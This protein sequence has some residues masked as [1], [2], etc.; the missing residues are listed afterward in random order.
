MTSRTMLLPQNA[1]PRRS[2][3]PAALV[4]TVLLFVLVAAACTS[5]SGGERSAD[6]LDLPLT[7]PAGEPTTLAAFTGK[8][9]VVNFFASWCGPCKAEL[10]DIEAVSKEYA[11]D[12]TIVGV[13][14]DATESS[15]LSLVDEIGVTFPTVFE[16]QTGAMFEAVDGRFMPTTIF[17]DA[18]GQ[19]VHSVAGLQTED[20]LRELIDTELLDTEPQEN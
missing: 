10:P 7:D 4:A 11:A 20:S 19:L 3:R 1:A 8:P 15:W 17:L 6:I 14:R 13:S 9:M 2:A 18:E 5:S 16:G 12:I